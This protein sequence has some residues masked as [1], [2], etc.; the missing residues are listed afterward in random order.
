MKRKNISGVKNPL[1]RT[2]RTVNFMT[3]KTC[4]EAEIK[5]HRKLAEWA[6]RLATPK[7]NVERK[8]FCIGIVHCEEFRPVLSH[9]SDYVILYC[10]GG[11][12]VSGGLDY[13]ANL[14]VKLAMATGF[15][16][17]SFAYRLAPEHPYPAA[18]E[19]VNAVWTYLMENV[20]QADHV[21]LAGDSAGGNMALCL[22]QRLISEGKP[23]PR[24]LIL[25]SPWTDMTGTAESYETN[26]D[27]DPI[28]T[29]NFV[30]NSAKAYKGENDPKDAAFSPLFGN[31]SNFPPVYVMAGKNGILLDDSI[32]LKEQLDL[33]GVKCDL[34]IEEKGWHVYQLMPGSMTRDAMKR[35]AAHVSEEL[36]GKC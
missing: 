24:E 34:D 26:Q 18:V 30:M 12:Y 13:A 1:V 6:G 28:L 25:F 23:A 21:L 7:G 19:D 4:S 35:L 32:H 3:G 20:A 14:S 36:Y 29:K 2:V 22:T 9:N 8:R 27:I 16:V 5:R 17:Y 31:F 33:A 10:H 11:G 15:T